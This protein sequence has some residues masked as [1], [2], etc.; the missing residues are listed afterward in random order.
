MDSLEKFTNKFAE[1]NFAGQLFIKRNT[2]AIDIF[3]W[4]NQ[5]SNLVKAPVSD[6]FG[7]HVEERLKYLDDL[8]CIIHRDGG[9]HIQDNGY[10][11]SY[12]KAC[13]KIF[14]WLEKDDSQNSR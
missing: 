12:K 4:F 1:P 7:E 8:L 10:A 13:E 14:N 5:E 9:H 11:G 2:R 3:N 6:D